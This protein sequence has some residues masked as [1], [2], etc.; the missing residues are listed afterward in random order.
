MEVLLH[1]LYSHTYI[2]THVDGS[3][4]TYTVLPYIYLDPC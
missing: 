3:T 2:W 1:I 4:V